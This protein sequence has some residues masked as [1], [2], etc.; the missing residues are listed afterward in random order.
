M[1]DAREF[2]K[3]RENTTGKMEEMKCFFVAKIK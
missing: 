1:A 2:F 3:L